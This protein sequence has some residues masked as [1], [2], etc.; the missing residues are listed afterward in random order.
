[1]ANKKNYTLKIAGPDDPIYK[2]EFQI[3]SVSSKQDYIQQRKK[4]EGLENQF[5]HTINPKQSREKILENL[6]KALQD[7]GWKLKR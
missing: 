5:L 4:K 3:Y 6:I 1:M 7:N 2:Q